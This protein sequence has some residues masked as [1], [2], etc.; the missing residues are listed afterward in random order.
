MSGPVPCWASILPA[1]PSNLRARHYGSDTLHFAT[2][3]CE[4][5]ELPDQAMDCVIAFEVIE[6]LA[7]WRKFLEECLRVLSPDGILLVSTPNKQLYAEARGEAGPNPFHVHEFEFSEFRDELARV[8]PHVR[9]IG[10][11]HAPSVVFR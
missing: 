2:G 6:H 10:Q 1:V 9:M 11:N 7:E 5:L 8:F 3:V 4:R